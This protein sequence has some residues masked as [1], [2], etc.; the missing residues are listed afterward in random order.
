M[1][2]ATPTSGAAPLTVSV[3]ASGSTNSPQAPIVNML[4]DC[5]TGSGPSEVSKPWIT[6]CN[7]VNPGT[8]TVTVL[9]YDLD[10][11][12]SQA[13]ATVTAKAVSPSPSP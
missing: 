4:I 12:S 9:V 7:Y 1:L 6:S 5:G 3:D 11:K 8:Y 10:T 13:S 2:K